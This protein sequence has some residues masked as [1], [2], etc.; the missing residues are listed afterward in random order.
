MST[1]TLEEVVRLYQYTFTDEYGMKLLWKLT[2]KLHRD[3]LQCKWKFSRNFDCY[4]S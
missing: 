2:R 1:L 4:E 3:V